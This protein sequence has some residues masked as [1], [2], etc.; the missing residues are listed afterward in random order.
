ML[1]SGSAPALRMREC[2][3]YWKKII[4]PLI[5]IVGTSAGSIV[6]SFMRQ[7]LRRFL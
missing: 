7:S 4:F 5:L 1:G 2:L 3:R 6:G